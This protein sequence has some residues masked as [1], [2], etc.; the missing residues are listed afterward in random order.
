M[1][2]RYRVTFGSGDHLHPN[3]AGMQAIANAIDLRLFAGTGASLP[4]G[5]VARWNFH[6][7]STGEVIEERSG[8][9]VRIA[10]TV[11]PTLGPVGDA[12]Q[13]DGYT[14]A[15]RGEA[16]NVLS[17]A[18]NTTIVCWLQLEAYPWNEVPILDQV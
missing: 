14:G 17:H 6:S 8:R 18:V 7:A 16:L 1:P 2:N 13:F 10:G 11:Y 15:L 4:V 9:F 5:V 12:L 3:D